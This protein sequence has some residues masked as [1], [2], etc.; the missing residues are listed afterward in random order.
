MLDLKGMGKVVNAVLVLRGKRRQSGPTGSTLASSIGQRH[1]LGWLT[2]SPIAL[3]RSYFCTKVRH[4][5]LPSDAL[6]RAPSEY[7]PCCRVICSNHG[8]FNHNQLA[9]LQ[10][11]V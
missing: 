10:I 2:S 5:H 8:S 6:Y 11:L 9:A 3:R 7:H 1:T 4:S